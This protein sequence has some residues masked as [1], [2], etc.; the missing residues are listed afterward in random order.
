[1]ESNNTK[2]TRAATAAIGLLAVLAVAVA[3]PARA[4]AQDATWNGLVVAPEARCSPYDSGDYRYS[5]SVE[6][7]IVRSL[8]DVYGPYTGRWFGST[9]ET[10][11][12][13]IVARSE[14]HD[15]GLCRA[16]QATRGQFSEDLRNLTL[17]GPSVTAIRSG[18]TTR[19]AGSRR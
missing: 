6:D 4:R 17:A 19:A 15:S 14:A 11:I 3:T 13:H 1:M 18:T 5:Q 9:R 7:G 16:D 12:E 10:D 2:I 8:G